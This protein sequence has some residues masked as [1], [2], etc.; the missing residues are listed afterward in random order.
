MYLAFEDATIRAGKNAFVVDDLTNVSGLGYD[1]FGGAVELFAEKM[2][3][4]G[5]TAIPALPV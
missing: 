1:T 4:E 3:G 5:K 2:L